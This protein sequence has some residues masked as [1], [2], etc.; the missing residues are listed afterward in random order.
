MS[1]PTTPTFPIPTPVSD[2]EYVRTLKP[3]ID[4]EYVRECRERMA[5]LRAKAQEDAA[6]IAELMHETVRPGKR[7]P[8]K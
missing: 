7:A 1:A 5:P 2:P 4:P 3:L 6:A 8:R